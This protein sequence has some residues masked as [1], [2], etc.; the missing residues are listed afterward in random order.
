MLPTFEEMHSKEIHSKKE[1]YDHSDLIPQVSFL[2]SYVQF[3][4]SV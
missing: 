2:Y 1:S 4:V 3:E